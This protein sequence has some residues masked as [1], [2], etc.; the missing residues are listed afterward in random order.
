MC[1]RLMTHKLAVG[2]AQMVMGSFLTLV[3]PRRSAPTL[4]V[5]AAFGF[6]RTLT[7]LT[8]Q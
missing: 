6:P 5:S 8:L 7:V 1:L 3:R 2:P 4:L